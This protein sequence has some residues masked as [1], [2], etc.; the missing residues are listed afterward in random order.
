MKRKIWTSLLTIVGLLLVTGYKQIDRKNIVKDYDGNI[1][2][3]VKI[4]KQVWMVENLKTT[5]YRNGDPI[6]HA[7]DD[8]EWSNIKIG[9][10]CNYDN[11]PNNSEIYGRLYKKEA[12]TDSRNIT[13]AGWHIPTS[14]DWKTLQTFLGGASLSGGK[15]KEAGT[16]H[17][18]DPNKGANNSSGFTGV[19]GGFRFSNGVFGSIGF[20]AHMWSSGWK[21]L[22]GSDAPWFRLVSSSE[23][24]INHNDYSEATGFSVRCIK[25][26]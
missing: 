17:W 12:I 23:Q 6:E 2:H 18:V 20:V 3:T 9:A 26:K 5:H 10:Y 14:D 1:Y 7:F 15:M 24:S 25:D 11:N 4:G 19:P 16:V 13:P 8:R 21:K 22:D